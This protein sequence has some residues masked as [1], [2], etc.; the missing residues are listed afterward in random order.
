MAKVET[1]C[2]NPH[3]SATLMF[4]RTSV[5]MKLRAQLLQTM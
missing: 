5:F 1:N 3:T 4:G 2:S